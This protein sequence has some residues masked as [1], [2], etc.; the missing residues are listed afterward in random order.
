MTAS[1]IAQATSLAS[2]LAKSFPS[3]EDSE[4]LRMSRIYAEDLP[5]TLRVALN[6]LR[7]SEQTAACLISG[8]PVEDDALGPTPSRFGGQPSPVSTLEPDTFFFLCGSLL[9]DPIGWETQQDGRLMHD[10]IA[11]RG[12]PRVQVAAQR[13]PVAWHT[14][15]A[16]HPCRAD[17]VGFMCLRDELS[18]ATTYASV[19]EIHLDPG[20][21]DILFQPR[22]LIQADDPHLAIDPASAHGTAQISVLFGDR[23]HP[24]LRLDPYLMVEPDDPPASAALGRLIEAL[25]QHLVAVPLAPGDALFIDNYRAVHG[26]HGF[27]P[28]F[29]GTDRWLKGLNIARDLRK[30]RTLRGGPDERVIFGLPAQAAGIG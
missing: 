15:D 13:I 28:R 23:R 3:T 20:D 27:R 4:F 7:L 6:R 9:G 26:R 14:E 25:Q 29:D 11:V 12:T 1:E 10:S 24:Y 18:S 16:A 5:R 30:S 17:Y 22:F 8:F 21:V 2:E 19:D